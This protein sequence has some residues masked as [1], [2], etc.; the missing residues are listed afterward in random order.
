MKI[1]NPKLIALGYTS[2]FELRPSTN[3]ETAYYVCYGKNLPRKY[4]HILIYETEVGPIPNGYIIHHK[5]G[6]GLNNNIDN[7]ECLSRA[8][9]MITHGK[10]IKID[11]R[12]MTLDQVMEEFKFNNKGNAVRALQRN[13]KCPRSK[14]FG[15]EVYYGEEE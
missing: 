1:T 4:H 9:H 3:P 14:F 15:H 11:G 7:L 6:N 8:N 2:M 13:N 10:R 12:Y 5:D